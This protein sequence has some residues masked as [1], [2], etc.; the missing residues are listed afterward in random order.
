MSGQ[1]DQPGSR[2]QAIPLQSWEH[3]SDGVG[4]RNSHQ[5]ISSSAFH[6]PYDTP[7]D[8]GARPS[9]PIDPTA[10]QAALPPDLGLPPPITT[11]AADERFSFEQ[12]GSYMDDSTGRNYVESDRVPLTAGLQSTSAPLSAQHGESLP[13]DSFQTVSDLGND[14]PRTSGMLHPNADPEHGYRPRRPSHGMSLDPNEYST[15]SRPTSTADALQIAGSMVRAM[16]QRVVNISGDAE[17]AEPRNSRQRSRSPRASWDTRHSRDPSLSGHIDTSYPSQ[18]QNLTGE[19][20]GDQRFSSTRVSDFPRPVVPNPLKGKSLG[21][22]GPDSAIR[23]KLCDLLVNPYVEPLILLLIVVQTILLTIESAPNVF[24]EGNGRP[25]R[26]GTKW[27]DWAILGLFIV[28][29]LELITRIIVSGFMLNAAEY[30][31]IDRSR[32]IRAAI[33]DQYRAVFQ[34]QQHKGPKAASVQFNPE[35]SMISRSFTTFMQGQQA[36]PKTQEEQQRF[37]LARRSFLRHSFNRLDF[38]AVVAYWISFV[39]GITGL[40]FK[41]KLYVFKMISCLRILRL[42]S[43][44]NGTAVRYMTQNSAF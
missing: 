40:E 28:F 31:T 43:I 2:R 33:E 44:T 4:N 24:K 36:I 12:G 32:G 16:S 19:K 30:S 27:V 20:N 41:Y 38:L 35:P 23:N 17:I 8:E 5:Q 3:F 9:S 18:T 13:R 15:S 22:F 14:Q 42:L 10:L 26:W 34:P 39:L 6:Q 21:V 1:G 37:Q 29:T 11:T 25:E 7:F